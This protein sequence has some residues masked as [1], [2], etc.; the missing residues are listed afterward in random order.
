MR[1]LS[2]R[3]KGLCPA[4]ER[5]GLEHS[6]HLDHDLK[7]GVK[8][9]LTGLLLDSE[10]KGTMYLS[11]MGRFQCAPPPLSSN[12]SLKLGISLRETGYMRKTYSWNPLYSC[13]IMFSYAYSPSTKR[14]SQVSSPSSSQDVERG[15]NSNPIQKGTRRSRDGFTSHYAINASPSLYSPQ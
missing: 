12:E 10:I 3:I 8:N 13:P 5:P 6:G 11:A 14:R 15:S 9:L 4:K 2:E 7:M 1:K